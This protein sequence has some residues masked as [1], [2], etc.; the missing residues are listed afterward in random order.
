[1]SAGKKASYDGSDGSAKDND[2]DEESE[3]KTAKE[4]L[5]ASL[6]RDLNMERDDATEED[7]MMELSHA[8]L[9]TR[10]LIE[11]S[12]G[13]ALVCIMSDPMVDV[14][15]NFADTINVDSF[16]VSF[17]VTPLA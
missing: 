1:M 15:D 6:W 13:A 10:A 11:L 17:L 4:T 7:E 2:G 16:Y 14:I 12:V 8:Q 5:M 3:K 9:M